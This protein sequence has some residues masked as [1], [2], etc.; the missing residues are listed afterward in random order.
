MAGAVESMYVCVFFKTLKHIWHTTH[1]VPETTVQN[2]KLDFHMVDGKMRKIIQCLATTLASSYANTVSEY[3]KMQIFHS[4]M[5][6]I[7]YTKENITLNICL[8]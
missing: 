1:P 3:V 5:N 7:N 4:H 2:F 6:E 8:E